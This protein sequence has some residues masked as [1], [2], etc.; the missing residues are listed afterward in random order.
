[1]EL[2][3]QEEVTFWTSAVTA[4]AFAAL[5]HPQT[6]FA[7]LQKS[8]QHEWQFIQRVIDDIG[9]CFFDVEAAITDIILPALYGETLKDCTYRRNLSAL[10][11]KFT[12]LTLP[13]P[14]ASSESNYETSTLVCSHILA[15]F[16]GTK[17]FSS[18]DHQS[19]PK[20]VTAEIKA[21]RSD[22]QDSTL[23][24]ILLDLDC[25]TR[26]TILQGKETGQ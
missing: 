5:S 9:D 16:R 1:M 8:L 3:V 19:L 26:R 15:A 21:H 18:A 14:S 13:D 11:V 10:P 24:T 22:K 25:D 7:G 17:S 23:S 12:G 2:W 20:V 4:L 6:A